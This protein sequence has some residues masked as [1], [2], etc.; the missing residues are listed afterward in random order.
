MKHFI[1]YFRTPFPK[2]VGFSPY[3]FPGLLVH[4]PVL[5][6]FVFLAFYSWAGETVL[7]T[8]VPFYL[9]IGLY[10]GRDLAI[11]AHYQPLIT[12]A[13]FGFCFVGVPFGLPRLLPKMQAFQASLGPRFIP[14]SLTISAILLIAFGLYVRKMSRPD[15]D[16]S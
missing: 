11:F 5:A 1:A 9:I 6:L 14:L 10:V 15:S 12:L 4:L 13:M 8:F 3:R 7:L 16:A 2:A